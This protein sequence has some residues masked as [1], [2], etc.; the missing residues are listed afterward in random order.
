[1]NNNSPIRILHV[2]GIMNFGGAESYIMNIYRNIDRSK[3][4]FDFIV[5]SSSKG[6]Y[7]DEI[8]DLGGRIFIV[9]QFKLYN[10]FKYIKAWKN[11]F[12]G[13]SDSRIIHSHIRSTASIF[14]PISKKYG[15]KSIIHSHSISAGI[16]ISAFVK[17][18]LQFPLKYIADYFFACSKEAGEWLFGRQLLSDGKVHIVNNSIDTQS[19]KYNIKTRNKIR[20]QLNL[21]GKFV[22]GHVGRFEYPKNHDFLIDVFKEV[23]SNYT[24]TI[25]LLVGY[26]S[27]EQQMVQKVKQLGLEDKVI[28][29]GR[30]TDISELLQSMDVFLFPSH[31]EGFPVTLIEAQASGLKIVA[32]ENIPSE[33]N[34]TDLIE[35]VSLKTPANVWK[36]KVLEHKDGYNR[37][38]MYRKV[39][40]KGFDIKS[41]T[42]WLEEFYYYVLGEN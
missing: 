1:M 32:S 40:S 7:D 8:F 2:F 33:V 20:K 3:V 22:I 18:I 41:N 16:G 17:N 37:N 10:I 6:H 29:L 25:L 12:N 5:H 4:Q 11:F 19:F 30:R 13:Y 31:F 9:P 35:F 24:N 23:N 38:D 39:L 36:Q 34:I 28:F 26:G 15:L 21:N 27:L 14:L 42:K